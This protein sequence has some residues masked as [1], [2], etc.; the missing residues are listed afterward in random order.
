MTSDT[1]ADLLERIGDLQVRLD[2]AEDTLS[3]L[4][5][6]EVDAII[7]SGPQG[8]QVYTLKGA[9]E[10]YRIMVEEMGEGAVTL[11]AD[12]LILFSNE[13]FSTMLHRP[14]ERVI[15]ARIEDFVAPEDAGLVSGLL[16]SAGRRKAEVRLTTGDAGFVPVYLSIQNVLLSG[17]ACCCVIVTDLSDQK[18]NAEIA[19]VL[20]AV[21]HSVEQQIGVIDGIQRQGQAGKFLGVERFVDTGVILGPRI[22]DF[23]SEDRF[24]LVFG[25]YAAG[26]PRIKDDLLLFRLVRRTG[27]F[28]VATECNQ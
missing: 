23:L 25:Q 7:A 3:A 20:E 13:R 12:G 18:R 2:E 17:T 15:G 10:A 19:A 11:T 9:D 24:D 8:D 28:G 21:P 26:V 14:L 5:N 16:R 6:G 27:P 4:R 22:F 1:R